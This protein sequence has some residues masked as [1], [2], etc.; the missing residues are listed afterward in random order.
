MSTT[1]IN[2]PSGTTT[3]GIIAVTPLTS[4]LAG[5]AVLGGTTSLAFSPNPSGPT[6]NFLPWSFG[7]SANPQS[8]R[9]LTN[10]YIQV[11]AGGGQA[12]NV[13]LADI[14][15]LTSDTLIN[16]TVTLASASSTSEQVIGSFRMPPGFLQLNARL[17]IC[18]QIAM[19]NNANAKTAQIRVNGLGGTL[20]F[21][22]PALASNA[23]YVLQCDIM[24]RGDGVSQISSGA[25]ATGGWGLSTTAY[26]TFSTVNYQQNEIEYVVTVTKATAGDLMTLEGMTIE[27]F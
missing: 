16:S 18:A 15:N 24:L 2:V 17:R 5:P 7:A 20:M 6:A 23:N 12:S 3:P 21:Q 4:I 11:T 13:V 10:G 25:G 19:V 22:S 27:L 1:V 14:N 8:F 9:P 26:P